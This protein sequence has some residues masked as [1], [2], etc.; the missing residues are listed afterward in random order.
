[1]AL[2][3]HNVLGGEVV[4]TIN[5]FLEPWMFRSPV[6]RMMPRQCRREFC[7]NG[8]APSARAVA[9]AHISSLVQSSIMISMS[10]GS[11]QLEAEIAEMMH[12]HRRY[13]PAFQVWAN[14]G[15]TQFFGSNDESESASQSE[16]ESSDGFEETPWISVPEQAV[17]ETEIAER[18]HQHRRYMRFF[19]IWANEGFTHFYGSTDESELASQIEDVSSDD[20]EEPSMIAV[21]ESVVSE[22]EIA[23]WM[24]HHNHSMIF[25]WDAYESQVPQ[26]WESDDSSDT[27]EYN[28]EPVSACRTEI[29]PNND[30]EEPL[31]IS[32]MEHSMAEI[33]IEEMANH[34]RHS[35]RFSGERYESQGCRVWESDDFSDAS[36]YNG[37]SDFTHRIEMESSD[38]FEER[39]FSSVALSDSSSG[40]DADIEECNRYCLRATRLPKVE[41]FGDVEAS[42]DNI[43]GCDADIE[44]IGECN[45]EWGNRTLDLVAMEDHVG[46]AEIYHQ[47]SSKNCNDLERQV[48]TLLA[49]YAGAAKVKNE[50]RVGQAKQKLRELFEAL[51]DGQDYKGAVLVNE[52]IKAFFFEELETQQAACLGKED[53]VGAAKVKE[54]LQALQVAT[55]GTYWQPQATRDY[56]EASVL[57]KN[58][59]SQAISMMRKLRN[60]FVATCAR[61]R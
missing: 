8:G 40:Y 6:W 57:Q 26:V 55:N 50:L 52:K 5:A 16:D 60:L 58:A 34:H 47:P 23:E 42:S 44:E 10:G 24:H 61:R 32:V 25:V 17:S 18:A 3:F 28:D 27:S 41:S 48:A 20:I 21:A 36:A 22:T 53:Y 15:F 33:D 45:R 54:K 37:E 14:E 13:M 12:R 19:E 46:A 43:D 59:L 2:A 11:G 56:A 1:M 29:E 49:E 39:S 7:V 9:V 38:D 4:N 31:L 51:L 30:F 35:M